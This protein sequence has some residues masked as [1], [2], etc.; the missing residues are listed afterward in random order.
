MA[1]GGTNLFHAGAGNERGE[2]ERERAEAAFYASFH[3]E[4]I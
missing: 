2:R 3:A 4:T 1:H